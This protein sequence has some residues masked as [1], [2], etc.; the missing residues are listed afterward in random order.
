MSEFLFV[1]TG[2]PN[3]PDQLQVVIG[4]DWN[5]S[6]VP[7]AE[8]DVITLN[9]VPEGGSKPVDANVWYTE[10]G[11]ADPN[12]STNRLRLRFLRSGGAVGAT[13]QIGV[14]IAPGINTTGASPTFYDAVS[15]KWLDSLYD[16]KEVFN[17]NTLLTYGW[18][19]N[20]DAFTG[21]T[22]Y[23]LINATA[24]T[25]FTNYNDGIFKSMTF[26]DN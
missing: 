26:I 25:G 17:N 23:Q 6:K 2:W 21:T 24:S 1:G 15:L 20:T 8:D 4:T 3:P 18:V 14:I 12:V 11:T 13:T 9:R 10:D 22:Q 5:D 19:A 16:F 7:F